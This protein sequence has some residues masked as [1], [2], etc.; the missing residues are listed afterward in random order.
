MNSALGGR[1]EIGVE[2]FRDKVALFLSELHA[3]IISA[4]SPHPG[5]IMGRSCFHSK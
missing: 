4:L 1:V 5:S 3:H 2:V